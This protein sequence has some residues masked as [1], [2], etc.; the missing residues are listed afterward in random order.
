MRQITGYQ[1]TDKKKKFDNRNRQSP[2]MKMVEPQETEGS[3]RL[4]SIA[5]EN[6]TCAI[7]FKVERLNA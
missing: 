1:L 2:I 4:D 7:E 3:L 6:P 5:T